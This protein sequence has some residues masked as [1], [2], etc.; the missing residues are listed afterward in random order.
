MEKQTNLIAVA[1]GVVLRGDRY[2]PA[3]DAPNLVRAAPA[4]HPSSPRPGTA[5][6][7]ARGL[8]PSMR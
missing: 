1:I 5:P 6:R 2:P 3:P 8:R 4:L 7:M